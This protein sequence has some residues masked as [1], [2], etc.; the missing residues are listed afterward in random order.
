MQGAVTLHPTLALYL[1][2][3]PVPDGI[4]QAYLTECRAHAKHAYL[5]L[6]FEFQP[7]R[8][9]E[10]FSYAC[11]TRLIQAVKQTGDYV[12]ANQRTSRSI[13]RATKSGFSPAAHGSL[14]YFIRQ[15]DVVICHRLGTMA[16]H[17]SSLCAGHGGAGTGDP[18]HSAFPACRS[19]GRSIQ[20]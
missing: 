13:R 4:I 5:N 12:I 7:V 11:G 1:R 3:S 9:I 6:K 10:K 2:L 17:S 8:A 16:A 18:R 20:P 14:Y 19:C 15:R